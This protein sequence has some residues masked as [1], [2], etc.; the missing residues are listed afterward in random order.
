MNEPVIC[1]DGMTYEKSSIKAYFDSDG[2][3][4]EGKK[5]PLTKKTIGT[6]LLPNCAMK[7]QISMWKDGLK[8]CGYIFN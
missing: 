5:S 1:E 7:S 2:Y 3:K 6:S 4:Y 8:E